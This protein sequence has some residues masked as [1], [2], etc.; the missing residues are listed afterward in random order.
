MLDSAHRESRMRIKVLAA[1]LILAVSPLDVNADECVTTQ[2]DLLKL[3]NDV[4]VATGLRFV[5]DPRVR[6]QV[7]LAGFKDSALDYATL[8]SV[9]EVHAFTAFESNGIIY[10]VPTAIAPDMKIKLGIG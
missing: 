2:S 6:A 4:S 10:V 5:V 3:I 9:L 8:L 7:T 1:L